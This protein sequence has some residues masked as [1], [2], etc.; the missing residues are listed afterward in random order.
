[1]TDIASVFQTIQVGKESS[2][3]SA[4]SANRLLQSMSVEGNVQA[5]VTM[6]RPTGQKSQAIAA[7]NK[8]SVAIKLSGQPT[9]A[10]IAF[11]LSSLITDA[12]AA[13]GLGDSYTRVYTMENQ[14]ADSPCSWTIERGS[15][16]R[17]HRYTGGSVTGM[18]FTFSRD[19]VTVAG[20][21]IGQLLEDDVQM[22][23]G[24]SVVSLKPILPTQ[25]SV[26]WADT[27]AGLSAAS[28][29]D[30]VLDAEFALSGKWGPL[31]TLDASKTSW[32][33][34]IETAPDC[35]LKVTMEADDTGMTPLGLMRT[36]DTKFFRI[37]A[38]GERIEASSAASYDHLFQ[39]DF[40]GK[41]SEIAEFADKEGI[42]ALGWTFTNVYDATWAKPFQITLV[43][44]LSAF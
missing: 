37:K 43:N 28:A 4:A 5:D 26:Y 15:S 16:T 35:T 29:L 17:A 7:L 41:V 8:E 2:V 14:Q 32:A 27:A 18:T 3:G 30:R 25:V 20:D 1:M 22:T 42:F 31:W 24:A 23:S 40:A 11:F 39:I 33:T 36:G 21:M 12:S 9:Y 13:S 34:T 38:A 44:T 19:E 10:E 6:F